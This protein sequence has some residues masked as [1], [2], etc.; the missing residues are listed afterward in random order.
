MNRT[1]AP[2]AK[3]RE[4]THSLEDI[5]ADLTPER[6]AAH[7]AAY[8]RGVHQALAFAGDLVDEATTLKQARRVL[9][10][11]E[12][13]AGR[14]RFVQK[15]RGGGMLLDHIRQQLTRPKGDSTR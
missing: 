11:A 15:N 12:N 9:T 7:E 5:A 2:S 4:L 14:L 8:R 10:R 3:T 1:T 13:M 6:R